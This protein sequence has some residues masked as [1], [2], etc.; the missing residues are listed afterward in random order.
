MRATNTLTVLSAVLF[1]VSLSPLERAQAESEI[2]PGREQVAQIAEKKAEIAKEEA[3]LA[4]EAEACFSEL[5]E[6]QAALAEKKATV[7]KEEAKVTK[8]TAEQAAAIEQKLAELNAKETERG[9]EL[10]LRDVL[11]ETDR[12]DL[13]PQALEDLY[14]M[15]IFLREDPERHILIEGHTDSIGSESYNLDLFQQRATA[16]R[17]FLERNGISPERIAT[18]G[19]G[20]VYPVA[21]NDTEAGRQQNRRVEVV[22]LHEG[23]LAAR[24][25]R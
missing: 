13:K 7:A 14:L 16:V 15:V 3:E 2:A 12:A 4:K 20:K 5:A 22:V 6:K 23:E 18:R 24:W 21:S 11:F 25:M 19:Y 10:T 9:L 8:K 1:V 17:N